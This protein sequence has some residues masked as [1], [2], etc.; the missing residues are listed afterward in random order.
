MPAIGRS[1]PPSGRPPA[2][3]T[4]DDRS[5]AP[6]EPDDLRPL[7]SAGRAA[8]R[9]LGT[10]LAAEGVR[11]HA[12]LSSPLLRARETAAEIARE[13]GADPETDERLSPGTDA[14]TLR[15]AVAGRA[16]R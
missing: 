10:R 6:G 3:R 11:P 13:L 5:L 1:Q 14:D 12:I 8:A 15:A 4:S 2:T 7:T 9:G 16:T